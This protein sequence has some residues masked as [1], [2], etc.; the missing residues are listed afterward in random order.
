M[1][2]TP[3]IKLENVYLK[4]EDL[5]ETGSA[6]DRAM[7]FQIEN[8]KKQDFKTA[9]ISSTGNAAISAAHFCHLNQINL[10]IFVSPKINQAKFDLLKKDG[11]QIFI[12]DQP[13]SESIKF[14]KKNHAYLL[15][16]STDPS[17]LIG[18]QEIGKEL[19]NKLPQ[20]TS[21]F[22]PVGSGTTLLGISQALP[23]SVKIYAV[24]PA[25]NCPLSKFFDSDYQPEIENITD[26]LSAKYLPLKSQII[27]AIKNSGGT[28]LIVQN[29][30][31]LEA[32]KI[33]DLNEIK[34]SLEGAL[35]FAGYKKAIKNN[36]NIGNY[37]VVIL[38]G[39]QR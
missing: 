10:T 27:S 20:I 26:A 1:A 15:R 2:N 16:Q 7:I 12:T 9:V 38:T 3:L 28:G 33:L 34:T 39:C 23:S 25:S 37:P 14:S 35:A 31:I 17:A 5:N 36:L 30:E 11:G 29:N 13:I 4:R 24:Q 21:I 32:Q 6:K 19:M 18:Y 22:V 8:L